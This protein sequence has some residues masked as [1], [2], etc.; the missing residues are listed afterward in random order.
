MMEK[1]PAWLPLHLGY[2]M[3]LKTSKEGDSFSSHDLSQKEKA[4]CDH[5]SFSPGRLITAYL[6]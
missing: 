5:T 1:S 3:V 6:Q 2:T 4:V